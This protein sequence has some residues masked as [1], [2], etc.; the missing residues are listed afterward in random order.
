MTTAMPQQ[1][2]CPTWQPEKRLSSDDRIWILTDIETHSSSFYP[3]SAEQ[4]WFKVG[5]YDLRTNCIGFVRF[6]IDDVRGMLRAGLPAAPW[7]APLAYGID[8]TRL[9][10]DGRC[11]GRFVVTVKLLDIEPELHAIVPAARRIFRDACRRSPRSA[12]G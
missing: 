1:R 7:N 12:A 9:A 2:I 10:H 4:R 6:S 3:S 8:V 11:E 5:A